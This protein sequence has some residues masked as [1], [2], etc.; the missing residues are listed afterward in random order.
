[1][2]NGKIENKDLRQFGIVLGVI[3]AIFG[4]I[5]LIKGHA[6]ARVWFFSG[7]VAILLCAVF[8]PRF[9]KPVYICFTKI[10][11]IIGWVNTR[12]I[13]ILVYY[14]ILTPIGIVLRMIGKDPLTRKIDKNAE[15]YWIKPQKT[16]PSRES[17]EKQF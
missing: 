4:G 2:K 13:L 3:L 8:M 16:I 10:A 7:S 9:L 12:I 1:M 11:K 14:L 15:T 5:H 6:A 17:L